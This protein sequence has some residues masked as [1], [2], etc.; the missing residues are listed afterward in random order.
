MKIKVH[1][2]NEIYQLSVVHEFKILHEGWE[3]DNLA[4]VVE[5]N[6]KNR[7]AVSNHGRFSL[8]ENREVKYLNKEIEKYQKIIED[9]E[10]AKELLK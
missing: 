4:Y 8:L 2:K 9:L 10:K 1:H 6:K 7:L 5:F 3:L